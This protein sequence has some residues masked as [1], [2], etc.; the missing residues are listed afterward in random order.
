[1]I[2]QKD[3]T[4]EVPLQSSEFDTLPKKQL[5]SLPLDSRSR[6]R[7]FE[8]IQ[9]KE[10][11]CDTS[12]AVSATEQPGAPAADG[13]SSIASTSKRPRYGSYDVG[14]EVAMPQLTDDTASCSASASAAAVDKSA[15]PIL[16]RR[17]SRS[18][19]YRPS[20]R[21]SSS[22]RNPVSPEDT[23]PPTP[24]AFSPSQS[25]TSHSSSRAAAPL[26]PFQRSS[27]ESLIFGGK[28][29]AL[30]LTFRSIGRGIRTRTYWPSVKYYVLVL[31][32]KHAGRS[33]KNFCSLS[34]YF[35]DLTLFPD[36]PEKS[37]YKYYPL[38]NH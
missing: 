12:P 20:H 19:Q 5:P 30:K 22:S 17:H 14:E 28:V 9:A 37:L 29:N 7:A 3:I 33:F 23:Q 38:E 21:L 1:M 10:T 36:F 15:D 4:D 13:A 2:L 32:Y 24:S 34:K 25:D 16:R 27:D 35:W 8:R 26:T 31:Q 11:S 6:A 18:S